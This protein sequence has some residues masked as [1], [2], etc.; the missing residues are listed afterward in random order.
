MV[1]GSVQQTVQ[2]ALL[3]PDFYDHPV[4]AVTHIETHISHVYLAGEFAYKI[5]KPVNFGFLD[6]SRRAR[7][8]FYCNE[9]VRLNG[10]FAPGLY[11][12]VVSIGGPAEN[13]RLH[14][15][16]ALEYAVKM[17]RFDQDRQLDRMLAA[18]RLRAEHLEAFAGRLAGIHASAP[19]APQD[20]RFGGPA[21]LMRP[22]LE[23]FRQLRRQIPEAG[24]NRRLD[25]L[26]DWSRSSFR[27]LE[28]RFRQRRS[29]G[30]IRECHGDIHLRNMAWIDE[31]P[32]FFDCIE[33]NPN[34]R[35]IDPVNDVAFL[36]MD[37]D[38]RGEEQ[39]AGYFLNRY[40]QQ[41]GDYRGAVL[42]NF[43]QVYR[44]LVR[45]KVAA[46]RLGQEQLTR[47]ERQE[48]RRVFDSYLA[49]AEDYSAP[50][51][52]A[53]LITHGPTGSG[54]SRFVREL[55]PR[56][57][58]LSLNSD[59]ERKRLCGLTAEERSDSALDRGIYT[60]RV[61]RRTYRRLHELA[62]DLTQAGITCLIDATYLCKTDR[63]MM[64]NLAAKRTLPL[65][66]LDF[67]LDRA[68]LLERIAQRAAG[69]PQ[70]SEGTAEVLDS[71]LRTRDPL[72]AEERGRVI[73]IT[74]ESS[75]AQI[76]AEI[77]RR[78]R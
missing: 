77:L 27:T 47:E 60:P 72:D 70:V 52:G 9:E 23:N 43:Y 69:G 33:F 42:L 65:L 6:F 10:R 17:R 66:I 21:A 12:G 45:A 71:Q 20:S 18:G 64:R 63:E 34:L 3:R 53:L 62:A 1:P 25:R 32:V 11:L 40:L 37:L 24:I 29:S 19:V 16:P 13:P 50:R 58:A 57:S 74:P 54:K 35:W 2:R 41:S 39:L 26:E 67:S 55:A 48:A 22:V 59:R 44:A 30:L 56:C 61:T 7:R 76:A 68:T 31:A 15:A 4:T 38:D 75:P 51:R 14:A 8:R 5:K 36:T 28:R 49:L 73:R 46:L 78:I